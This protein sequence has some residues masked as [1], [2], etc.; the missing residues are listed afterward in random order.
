M[1][2]NAATMRILI[3]GGKVVN[4]DCTLE[5]DVYIENG[6]I[7]QVGRELMIPGGAKVIDAT[8]KLVIPG[9]IDTS[10]HF[11]QTF[12]NAT[13]VDDF[14]HGTKVPPGTA[15]CSPTAP[16]PVTVG[17]LPAQG[18]LPGPAGCAWGAQIPPAGDGSAQGSGSWVL[19]QPRGHADGIWL[20]CPAANSGARLCRRSQPCHAEPGSSPARPGEMTLSCDSFYSANHQVFGSEEPSG[21]AGSQPCCRRDAAWLGTALPAAGLRL[22]LPA[23][24]CAQHPAGMAGT[25]CS[26]PRGIPGDLSS[27][28]AALGGPWGRRCR[29]PGAA[30]HAPRT[31]QALCRA[32]AGRAW[33]WGGGAGC[34]CAMARRGD[35]VVTAGTPCRA[36]P[37]PPGPIAK[38]ALGISRAG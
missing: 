7:Q 4:D 34:C 31:Q 21:R 5:A 37:T 26:V 18:G 6:I 24:S 29:A 2:A 15:L 9:G 16:A 35:S 23:P 33:L 32:G 12:M 25:W 27:P 8:G 14:Y 3:K 20:P 11:H 19:D 17:L 10:T 36:F 1:L 38:G 28:S 22:L 13:C 30:A